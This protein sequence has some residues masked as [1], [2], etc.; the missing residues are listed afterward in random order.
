MP[1]GSVTVDTN[2]SGKRVYRVR[3]DVP[4]ATAGRA[5]RQRT[6]TT[7]R[8]A[9][10][11]LAKT[12]AALSGNTYIEPV[13]TPTG[14]YLREWADNI[15][16]SR[17]PSTIYQ[18]RTTIA[19]RF[20]A[21]ADIPLADLKPMHIQRLLVAWKDDGYAPST[22]NTTFR[23][24][25]TALRDAVRNG[26]I[27]SDPTANIPIPSG[28]RP[29]RAVWSGAYIQQ[30][31]VAT[32]HT[33]D[34]PI[35]VT[36]FST[37]ARVGEICALRLADLD[38]QFNT[39]IIART[40]R[41]SAQGGWHIGEDA[42]SETSARIIPAS[43]HLLTLLANL[44]RTDDLVFH[45]ETGTP[46]TEAY[47]YS[48]LQSAIRK[49]PDLPPLTPHGARHSGATWLI[50]QGTPIKVVSQY[51]GH[52]DAAFTLRMYVHHDADARKR[53]ANALSELTGAQTV[54]NPATATTETPESPG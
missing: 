8:A 17:K 47:V 20:D 7:K 46:L 30:F 10:E 44:P 35:W 32:E 29:A 14:R 37:L 6:F 19:N 3:Y 34:Y 51:L 36:L 16:P 23:T 1:R 25:R 26:H 18:Y 45:Q 41:R 48:R 21:I 42:K 15:G 24:L 43:P 31:L 27:S 5:Q 40:L 54:R 38:F 39:I 2:S 28:R 13:R 11:F 50:E 12:L 9:D 49:V 33:H 53:A 52:A 22:Q 4:S